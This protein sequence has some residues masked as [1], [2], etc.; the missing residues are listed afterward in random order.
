[1]DIAKLI[2][3]VQE[4]ETQFEPQNVFEQAT[5]GQYLGREWK[6]NESAH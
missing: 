6:K 4:Y 2:V 3:T 1:M 5:K